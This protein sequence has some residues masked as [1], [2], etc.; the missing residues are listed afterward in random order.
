MENDDI[1]YFFEAHTYT[2]YDRG[3]IIL[4][5][6]SI[7]VVRNGELP[8]SVTR[9]NCDVRLIRRS[10]QVFPMDKDQQ[11]NMTIRLDFKH[12]KK[13]IIKTINV[14][15]RTTLKMLIEP[16]DGISCNIEGINFMLSGIKLAAIKICSAYKK[17]VQSVQ[18]KP[19]LRERA[20]MPM[21][22]KAGLLLH[23]AV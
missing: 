14:L 21:I 15:S 7:D 3:G 18:L 9:I 20:Y 23:T 22:P 8:E 6:T 5:V 11:C 2:L 1:C 4:P 13:R 19:V 16:S 10:K 12:P 17:T